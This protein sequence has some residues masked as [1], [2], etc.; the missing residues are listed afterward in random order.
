MPNFPR[1]LPANLAGLLDPF[2]EVLGPLVPRADAERARA[3]LESID[4]MSVI[5]LGLEV[6]LP[7]HDAACDISVL[8]PARR[9]PAFVD[10]RHVS[11]ALLAEAG[12]EGDSTW[13]ELDT[14]NEAPAVGAFIRV[15]DDSLM[16]VRAAASTRAGLSD[17]VDALVT[18]IAP[19]W[20]GMGRLIGFFPDRRPLPVAA[21]LLP[22]RMTD[23][24]TRLRE[25]APRATA[26]VESEGALTAHLMAHV[27]MGALAVGA[28]AEGR[29]A[30]SW[31]GSFRER[32][33]AMA[34]DCWAPLLTPS[35][36]WGAA[37][38]SLH[39]LLDVQGIHTFDS[40]P[41]VRM[42]SGIDHIK[43]GP[44]GKVKA[45]VGAH[46]VSPSYR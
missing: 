12:G 26:C 34:D 38:R 25:L 21:A 43:V 19:Y 24:P 29:T 17:A 4:V 10:G 20:D 18:L 28:D 35:P 40:L 23:G 31:E 44:D 14:S 33:K 42:L 27:D 6:V 32:E 39:R 36:V 13:W 46:I 2:L 30:V 11:L 15:R 37:G 3:A 7:P 16:Q 22:G 1:R 45:Y 5:S 9:T 41:T 8:M